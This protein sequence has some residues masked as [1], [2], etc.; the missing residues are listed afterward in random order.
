[1]SVALDKGRLTNAV[2]VIKVAFVF[3]RCLQVGDARCHNPI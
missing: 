2:Y 3:D 1:M